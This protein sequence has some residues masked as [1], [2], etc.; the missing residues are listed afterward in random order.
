MREKICEMVSVMKKA[1]TVDDE[2]ADQEHEKVTRLET[3]NRGLKEMLNI[4]RRLGVNLMS[5]VLT[6][7]QAV[8]TSDEDLI[9]P[10]NLNEI[11]DDDDITPESSE[12]GDLSDDLDNSVIENPK[13][14]P[15][16]S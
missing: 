5:D 14:S 7:S 16:S 10:D 15:S 6:H 9:E 11:D 2:N 12:V 8:Q 4:H 3:E 1:A 13:K